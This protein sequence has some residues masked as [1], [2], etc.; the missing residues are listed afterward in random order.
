MHWSAPALSSPLPRWHR[1]R[2]CRDNFYPLE[3]RHSATT[4]PVCARLVRRRFYPPHALTILPIRKRIR[5]V[6]TFPSFNIPY[7][8]TKWFI[9]MLFQFSIQGLTL[10]SYQWTQIADDILAYLAVNYGVIFL[11]PIT[12]TS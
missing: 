5:Y 4:D 7:T 2:Q 12:F 3:L 11:S 8:Y 1:I 6:L 9:V 10:P